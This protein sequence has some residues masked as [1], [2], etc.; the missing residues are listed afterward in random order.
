MYASSSALAPSPSVAALNPPIDM[1]AVVGTVRAASA[2]A[3]ATPTRHDAHDLP[4]QPTPLLDREVERAAALSLLGRDDVRLVTLTGPGGV[5]KSH[6]ALAVAE[7]AADWFPGGIRFVDLARYEDNPAACAAIRAALSSVQ[8]DVPW[9][10]DDPGNARQVPSDRRVLLILDNCAHLLPE[11]ARDIADLLSADAGVVVLATS[12]EPLRLRW[13]HRLPVPPL[14][15]PAPG[16]EHSPEALLAAPA[17]AL[18]VAR[19]RAARPDFA[20]TPE[21]GPA[22][23]ELCRRLDGLPLAIELAAACVDLLGPTALLQR[24]QRHLPLP[25]RAAEDLPARHRT[26]DAAIGWSYE[27]LGS[28]ERWLLRR[29]APLPSEWTLGQAEEVA[30]RAPGFDV[31]AALQALV[32]KGLVA[33]IPQ[34]EPH[35]GMLQTVRAYAADLEM[36]AGS[37]PDVL[38]DSTL[39]VP[40]D[41]PLSARER[42]VLRLVAEGLPSKLIGRELGLAERTVKSHLS[43]AMNKLGAFTRAQALAIALQRRYV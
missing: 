28:A 41:N 23:E 5:G 9:P 32:D 40:V 22:V 11:L 30:D 14:G 42:A 15:L 31:L 36:P 6:L 13:E 20:L 29:L 35:F 2:R 26:L 39:S 38:T 8:F 27:R 4:P 18:F 3:A 37:G 25:S 12:R 43:G 17:V 34:D 16:D 21:N 7:A 1:M 24:L 10:S 19:A 33:C